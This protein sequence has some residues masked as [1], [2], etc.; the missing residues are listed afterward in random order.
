MSS[1]FMKKLPFSSTTESRFE[2]TL[3]KCNVVN[4]QQHEKT[5]K[6]SINLVIFNEDKKDNTNDINVYILEI[7]MLKKHLDEKNDEIAR[8]NI[9]AK[10]YCDTIKKQSEVIMKHQER[11][12]KH[13]NIIQE[14]HIEI[15]T[16]KEK[17]ANIIKNVKS[18]NG[19]IDNLER[20][21]ME[22]KNDLF[23]ELLHSM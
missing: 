22:K 4:F 16:L 10:N 7:S 8:M 19:D 17:N 23:N 5:K 13:E 14:Q 3:C 11:I 18:Y 1:P 9:V 2:C 12:E 20:A 15:I 21:V 6:H